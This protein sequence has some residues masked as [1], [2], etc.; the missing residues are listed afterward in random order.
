MELKEGI[1]QINQSV[2]QSS[3]S[4]ATLEGYM[5]ELK[6]ANGNLVDKQPVSKLESLVYNYLTTKRQGELAKVMSVQESLGGANDNVFIMFHRKSDNYPLMV[7]PDKWASYQNSGEVATGVA[8]VA[9]ERILVVAPTKASLNW[10]SANVA[11][12]GK[13]TADRPTALGDFDGKANTA[14]QITHA[15]CRG[16]SYAAGYCAQYSRVNANGQG[17]T[18]GSW[19]L[20]SIGELMMIHA[21]KDKINYA[22]SL[23]DA[24]T[25]L[26]GN[27]NWSSTE[28]SDTNAWRLP[29]ADGSAYYG[30]KVA[31]QGAVRPVS[32]ISLNLPSFYKD[33]ATMKE[34]EQ[35]ARDAN[36]VFFPNQNE[37]NSYYKI[38]YNFSDI[39]SGTA[40]FVADFYCAYGNA[41]LFKYTIAA[42]KMSNGVFYTITSDCP[43]N[44]RFFYNANKE[45]FIC[46][47]Y[48]GDRK[49]LSVTG[50]VTSVEKIG[51]TPPEGLTEIPLSN[52]YVSYMKDYENV[53]ELADDMGGYRHVRD[54]SSSENMDD[55]KQT[56]EYHIITEQHP[57]NMPSGIDY[58]T[59]TKCF[60]NSKGNITIQELYP[61]A[62]EPYYR[63][64]YKNSNTWYDWTPLSTGIPSFYKDYPDIASLSSA[65]S[66]QPVMAGVN[67]N[68]FIMF[69]RKDTNYPF[70][71]KPDKWASYQNSGEIATGVVVADGERFLVIALT[72]ASL[73]WS[74][75][76]VSA[77]GKTITNI[78]EVLVD[79]DGKA[80]TAAQIT[81]AECSGASYAAGYCA[82]YSR[83]NANGQGLTA[84]S[85]WLPSMGE[86]MMI[87][88]NKDKIDYA[89]SLIS[90]ATKLS[91]NWYWSST[92]YSSTN[93]WVLYLSNGF[94]SNHTKAPNQGKVRAVSSISLNLPSF[95][96]DYNS[97]SELKDALKA[98]W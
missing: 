82:Q 49:I 11:G 38:N 26:S 83:V 7:K 46:P 3:A 29:I 95:Y 69:N 90:G 60:V 61:L 42:S 40:T 19:W 74:S 23:I 62:G 18:A 66:L 96:K 64:Y 27:W 36:E 67:D 44:V 92:E 56:G 5:L 13:T 25:Q 65:I 8:V 35:G 52:G 4:D 32:S 86:L 34:L 2:T 63:L 20:P 91:E 57:S 37:L 1:K 6:D 72:E 58:R 73:Y 84:G 85:W 59:S 89:L 50:K 75:A 16:A 47:Q 94:A 54:I 77:G 87:Y 14:S 88:A 78:R 21:N 33:Y 71:V 28:Y 22:L 31:G 15:E 98:I 45:L 53:G 17:L 93:A 39:R 12:G 24:S 51:A 41:P 30:T 76:P 48:G 81:H 97:L 43:S 10:S 55:I 9:G 79:F 68:V 70:M 80:S